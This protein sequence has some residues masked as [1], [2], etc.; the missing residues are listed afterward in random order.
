MR[1]CAPSLRAPGFRVTDHE[2]VV[3]LVKSRLTKQCQAEQLVGARV[4]LGKGLRVILHGT[5]R[6]QSRNRRCSVGSARPNL[7]TAYFDLNRRTRPKVGNRGL[8]DPMAGASLRG[9][10]DASPDTEAGS[11]CLEGCP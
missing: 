3:Q 9:W 7:S 11:T 5:E 8:H 10:G 2:L 1:K 6:E 4:A